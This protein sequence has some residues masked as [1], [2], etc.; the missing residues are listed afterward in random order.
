MTRANY[1]VLI[2]GYEKESLEQ[3]T[4][5]RVGGYHQPSLSKVQDVSKPKSFPE[6]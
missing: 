2:V 3:K 5:S 6:A 4:G 1:D